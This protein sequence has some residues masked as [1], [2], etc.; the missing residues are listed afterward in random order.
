MKSTIAT[1]IAEAK[2]NF[3][4]QKEGFQRAARDLVEEWHQNSLRNFDALQMRIS[5]H[6][7]NDGYSE[8]R[9]VIAKEKPVEEFTKID[10]SMPCMLSMYF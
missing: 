2:K 3:D 9:P 8:K 6:F 4:A 1:V 5:E 7:L 10:R